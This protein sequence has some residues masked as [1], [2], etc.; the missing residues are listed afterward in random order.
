MIA[1]KKILKVQSF[2]NIVGTKFSFEAMR[3]TF[4]KSLVYYNITIPVSD[5]FYIWFKF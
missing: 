5:F 2:Y 4:P 1:L 3:A